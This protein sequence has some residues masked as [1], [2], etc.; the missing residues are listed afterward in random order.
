M[1]WLPAVLGALVAGAFG[2]ASVWL[3]Y[4]TR[5]RLGLPSTLDEEMTAREHSIRESLKA[6]EERCQADLTDARSE[7]AG[8]ER[9]RVDLEQR[10]DRL[11]ELFDDQQLYIQRLEARL[12]RLERQG[13][14][15]GA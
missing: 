15:P 8:E 2:F 13:G 7:L 6:A 14:S 11:Q 3:G 12:N 9:K 4:R 1:E 10:H 5:R